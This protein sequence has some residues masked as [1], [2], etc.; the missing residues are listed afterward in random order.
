MRAMDGRIVRCSIISSCL[1]AADVKDC[2]S[3]LITSLTRV[4]NVVGLW[5]TGPYVVFT[6]AIW[7]THNAE[8]DV[9]SNSG[10]NLAKQWLTLLCE[11][12]EQ[13]LQELN[14]DYPNGYRYFISSEWTFG[15]LLDRILL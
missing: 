9:G 4:N 3:L 8:E 11:Q 2:K 10:K 6:L 12:Y 7:S 1:S 14:N 5:N 15:K 13:L